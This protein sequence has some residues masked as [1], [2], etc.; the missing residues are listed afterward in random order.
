[1]FGRSTSSFDR[2]LEKATS[3]LLL[4][5]DWTSNLM[6]CDAIRQGDTNPKYAI[7]AIKKKF[8]HQNPHAALFALQVMETCV[9]NCGDLVHQEIA[10][11]AFMEEMRDLVKQTTDD[12]IKNKVLE[13]IQTWG[14][15][16]RS[17]SK[18][19]IVTDTLNLMKAEG[20]KFPPIREADAMFEADT[21]PEWAEGDVC[22]R[23]RVQFSTFTRQHH[24]RACGQVFC[25]KCS[26]KSCLL[27]KFGIEREVRVCDSCFDK[28]GP[29]DETEGGGT[30]S[31]QHQPKQ[32]PLN[33]QAA[34]K[35]VGLPEEYISSPLS[36]QSQ[37]PAKSQQQ[38]QPQQ[39]GGPAT[40][41]KGQQGGGGKSEAELKE[42]EELQLVLALSMSEAEEKEKQKKKQTNDILASIENKSKVTN[43]A[44]TPPE[45]NSDPE[46]AKYLNRDYWEAKK[47][48]TKDA[49]GG[50][51]NMPT[52]VTL[53]K[54]NVMAST[55]ARVQEAIQGSGNS[56]IQTASEA[57]LEEFTTSLRTQ[58]EIFVNRMKSNSSRGR[59]I[60]NDSSVQSLFV[61][62]MT[63]HSRLVK[64]I[65]EQEDA[66]LHY[67]GLQDKLTQVR[68]ARAALDALREE[69]RERR[70]REAEEAERQRQIQMA[71]KLEQ[72]RKK[73]AEYLEYQRQMALKRMADQE[74]EMALI[75]DASRKKNYMSQQ[76]NMYNMYLPYTQANMYPPGM[77]GP[78]APQ[79][80]P[81]GMIGPQGMMA[82]MPGLPG[83]QPGAM[84]GQ[85][86]GAMPGQQPGMP[87]Q[88]GMM[89]PPG[90]VGMEGSGMPSAEQQQ[91]QGG[92]Q[93]YGQQQQQQQPQAA[94]QQ[95][96]PQAAVQQQQPQAAVQQQQ[97]QVAGYPGQSGQQQ[98]EENSFNM[99]GMAGALPQASTGAD[100]TPGG[101]MGGAAAPQQ[102]MPPNTTVGPQGQVYTSQAP[103]SGQPEA[104]GQAQTQA[105]AP[106]IMTQP[107]MLPHQQ[108][109]GAR[110]VLAGG[111]QQPQPAAGMPQ[112][113]LPAGMPP[114]TTMQQ[115]GVVT[116]GHPGMVQQPPPQGGAGVP[117]EM[118]PN[119]PAPSQEEDSL[120]VF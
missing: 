1:M 83:Q 49:A 70:R 102:S 42:E 116:G 105:P 106:G 50:G 22:R 19:R 15:V 99:H 5:P 113:Q 92:Y 63:M 24:C 75:Q 37:A 103:S 65:Q 77:Q 20:W 101:M 111:Q 80:F 27:P 7:T 2:L 28:Y 17:Q 45:E 114:P 100:S 108:G 41:A 21:A 74:R 87:M 89:M 40:G 64:Y 118:A 44:R 109:M 96:Q 112:Q 39:G 23:C 54:Q 58:L 25:G 36:K 61:N 16:F 110:P 3:Q 85:Q 94:V 11:K 8:Y 66:R 56:S 14:T 95:Q 6:I 31:P 98:P 115:G 68:D 4:E 78:A 82:G 55:A 69:E 73:K 30:T 90:G 51:G 107:G 81:P 26:A 117:N 97:Q 67:E 34:M 29:K 60:A 35:E 52:G 59:P 57:E 86:P 62:M 72:M 32:A 10:T 119:P 38:Q 48:E 91:Q 13:L 84:A 104:P 47:D 18:Y 120:I 12:N 76:Q 33:L 88:P 46:L 71:Y 9:K 53:A 93:F 79:G 43:G